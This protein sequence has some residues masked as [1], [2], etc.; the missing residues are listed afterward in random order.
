MRLD[1]SVVMLWQQH[2]HANSASELHENVIT[3]MG[4]MCVVVVVLHNKSGINHMYIWYFYMCVLFSVNSTSV[5]AHLL[6]PRLVFN[7][8]HGALIFPK[9]R[10]VTCS[11]T[12]PLLGELPDVC[13]HAVGRA[14]PVM[15]QTVNWLQSD[16]YPRLSCKMA[17]CER[18]I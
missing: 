14:N 1:W 9:G 4:Q 18:R 10:G 16:L 7:M 12:C 5:T 2:Q 17:A 11:I 3:V 6:L 8:G 15:T 13:D